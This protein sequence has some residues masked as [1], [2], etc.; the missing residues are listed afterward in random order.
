M[1]TLWNIGAIQKNFESRDSAADRAKAGAAIDTSGKPPGHP[2]NPIVSAPA[3]RRIYS[4]SHAAP[5]CSSARALPRIG[6]PDPGSR[7]R[8]PIN[9]RDRGKA[10]TRACPARLR[11]C[12]AARHRRRLNFYEMAD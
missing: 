5:R 1:F 12:R 8:A 11:L 6:S 9:D 2:T 3:P 7:V 4:R 10:R